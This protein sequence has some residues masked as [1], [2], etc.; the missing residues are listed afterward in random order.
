MA[1]LSKQFKDALSMIEPG[2][3]AGHAAD[4]HAGVRDVLGAEKELVD[5]GLHTILIG[6]YKREVSIRRVKDVDVFCELPNL[7]DDQDPQE[8]LDKFSAVLRK[9]YG[10]DRVSKNDRSV[11]VEF[12]EFDMHVDVVP[13]RVCDDAWEIPDK[14]GGWEK[15][16]PI[17]FGELTTARNT[18]HGGDYVPTIKLLRQTRRAQLGD[19][20]P[21]GFFVEIAAYHAFS[22]IPKAD[23]DDAP[24]S[25]AEYYTVALEKMAPLLRDHADGKEPLMNPAVSEQELHVRAT[26]DELDQIADAWEQAGEDARAALSSEDDQAAARVF[27]HLLGTNSDGDEVFAVPAPSTS[28]AAATSARTPGHTNLPS[29]D[30]PTFA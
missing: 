15:T 7:P 5:W 30:S 27:K 24:A 8:L 17:R 10:D 26:Q 12:P 22:D 11:K 25:S 13:A 16:D 14:D 18:D 21:G 9:S 20:K 1:V 19:A 28:A 29:G 23:G 6:S 2:D 4:S 3:D